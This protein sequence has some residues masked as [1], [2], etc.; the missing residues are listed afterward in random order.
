MDTV[1]RKPGE[2]GKPRSV[3]MGYVDHRSES[4]FVYPAIYI[5]LSRGIVV[6][7]DGVVM[8]ARPLPVQT[9]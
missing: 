4:D 2:G 6:P 8:W 5:S 7:S 3:R 9:P 1:L